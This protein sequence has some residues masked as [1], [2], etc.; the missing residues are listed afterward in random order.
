MKILLVWL[1]NAAAL[2]ALPYLFDSIRVDTFYTALIVALILSII[3]TV[4]RPILLVLT[5]PI[6]V[7]TLGLFIL[8][9]NGL[10][11]WFVASFVKG[12]T[13]AGFW[14]AVFGAIAYS[15]ISWAASAVI[16]GKEK[17]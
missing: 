3:N 17:D 1:I 10:L 15:V 8:V 5:L 14:P 7:V 9:L 2:F 6:T 12:F 16:L 13:I 4:I 11:L